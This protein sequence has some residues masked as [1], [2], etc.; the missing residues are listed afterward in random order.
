MIMNLKKLIYIILLIVL[1]APILLLYFSFNGNP[2]SKY[3][4]KKGLN[5]FLETEFANSEYRI[6]DD[7]VYN[8]KFK[9]YIYSVTE[10]RDNDRI[11][12][13]FEVRGL[14]KPKE[15]HYYPTNVD[16]TLQI[17]FNDQITVELKAELE[18]EIPGIV[19]YIEPFTEVLEGKY[20]SD[21]KWSH[22][23]ELIRPFDIL[24][25]L[26]VTT[27]TKEETLEAAQIIQGTLQDYPYG[28]ARVEGYEK[29][30]DEYSLYSIKFNH[31]TKLTIESISEHKD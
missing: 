28:Q 25:L 24:F 29:G 31:H 5:E 30:I 8:F 26:D 14:I 20:P 12:Y 21:T 27:L 1:I 6:N 18:K 19:T 13:E 11:E 15:I 22:D 7:G 9:N 10:F 4:L 23:I 16:E 17:K 3:F 2:G